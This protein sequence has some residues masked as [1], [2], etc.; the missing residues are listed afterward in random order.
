MDQ[1]RME[2]SVM[3]HASPRMPLSK[4]VVLATILA[5]I[6]FVSLIVYFLTPQDPRGRRRVEVTWNLFLLACWVGAVGYWFF[7]QRGFGVAAIIMLFTLQIC[8]TLPV[9]LP[10]PPTR[11]T[12]FAILAG[13]WVIALLQL[14]YRY[15]PTGVRGNSALVLFVFMLL[16]YA[17]GTWFILTRKSD[18]FIESD[19]KPMASKIGA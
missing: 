1:L 3:D 7:L 5:P 11:R 8:D 10:K 16:I 4:R 17:E 14:Q 18:P 13:G 15:D 2:P 12:H 6:A 9:L 19:D